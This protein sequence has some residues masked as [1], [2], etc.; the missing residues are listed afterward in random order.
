MND[1][2]PNFL[3]RVELEP[4]SSVVAGSVG[5]WTVRYTV[6][7]A[8]LDEGGT[9][10]LAKRFASDWEKPQFDRPAESGYTTVITDG[11]AKLAVR[12][13]KKAH[14][15]PWMNWCIV[16]DVYDGSLGPGDVISVV[17]G[18]RSQGSPGI[19]AQTFIE[20]N[21]DFRVFAD[22][23]NAAVARS[24]PGSPTVAVIAGEPVEL[25]AIVPT[26]AMVGE[27]IEFRVRGQD[28]WM[29][30][31]LTPTPPACAW[32][33]DP[34]IEWRA[35]SFRL[36]TPG[37]V[38]I[39][40]DQ[41]GFTAVSNP[42]TATAS[43][44][45]LKQYWGDLH[46]QSD[47]TVGTGTEEEYF[48]FCR[49][50]ACSDIASHQ[51]ND[52]QMD[53]EDWSRLNTVVKKF[54]EPGRFVVLP[55]YEW[56][57]NTP[58]GGD[59]NVFFS[60]DDQ[61]IYRSSH[62][63]IPEVAESSQTPAH[64]ANELFARIR[65]NGKAILGAHVG[66]RYADIRN[67]FDQDI[68]PLVEVL[69]CW[70]VFEWLLWDAFEMGYIVGV[71]ANSDGHKGRPGAEGPGAGDFGI[72]GGLTCVLAESLTREAVFNALK[73]RH[74]YGTSGPRIDLRFEAGGKPMGSVLRGVDGELE[75]KASVKGT[76][77]IESLAL[78]HGREIIELVRPTS[79][80]KLTDTK[81][82]RVT[83]EGARMRGRGRRIDW[84]GSLKVAGAK[85]VR[86]ETVAF[87]SPADG[88]REAGDSEVTFGSRTTGDMDGID[89]WLDSSAEVRV[90]LD[91]AVG[92][93][94]VERADLEAT[95]ER[96]WDLDGL[97]QRVTIRLYPERVFETELELTRKITSSAEGL[98][99]YFVKAT[100][101][102]G[103]AAWS[104][105]IYVGRKTA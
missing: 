80:S 77:P 88:I 101:I 12:F 21:H 66:G 48:R 55:G 59:R 47:A 93:F 50:Q 85:I 44:S 100:Q 89:L 71:M 64:P 105:P 75:L 69:S 91:S 76:A 22:P 97:D 96:T 68:C 57:A 10:K 58:A 37:T 25:V 62:W 5:Q 35:G 4:R 38:R 42:I 3:G 23:T 67:H 14:D 26:Q 70:G 82:I 43:A 40:V 79:F 8:G 81:Q 13:A 1:Q 56:S 2:Q 54:N 27:W 95:G 65:E 92:S 24:V 99:P 39:M 29:N 11:P 51:G 28:R 104:S 72:A 16:I 49:D 60:E 33:G 63:Q 73:E 87:D 30:P 52:F 32:L 9:L 86:A 45:P 17:L 90:T 61:P 18:D 31:T 15:R 78:Y 34:D 53:D 74:C 36:K 94:T 6:G 98:T 83:W 84:S 46:A 103:H 102:D 20:S 41:S 7:D 19:R